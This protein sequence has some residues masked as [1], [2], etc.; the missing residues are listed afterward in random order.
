M[1]VVLVVLVQFSLQ[2]SDIRLQGIPPP[3]KSSNSTEAIHGNVSLRFSLPL[4]NFLLAVSP[5]LCVSCLLQMS[6]SPN[7]NAIISSTTSQSFTF[8]LTFLKNVSSVNTLM[9]TPASP[10]LTFSDAL[11]ACMVRAASVKAGV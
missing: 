9:P 1:M 11:W 4:Q 7:M 3:V 8:I 6:P 2:I 5:N 10:L